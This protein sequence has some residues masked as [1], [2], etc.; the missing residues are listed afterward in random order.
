MRICFSERL[1]VFPYLL[2]LSSFCVCGPAELRSRQQTLSSKRW[3]C[4][5]SWCHGQLGLQ[6]HTS[7]YLCV[8][9]WENVTFDFLMHSSLI[10]SAAYP[11]EEQLNRDT[12]PAFVSRLIFLSLNGQNVL[13]RSSWTCE[14]S[15]FIPLRFFCRRTSSTPTASL[16]TSSA[17]KYSIP[18]SLPFLL[19]VI[20]CYFCACVCMCVCL[21]SFPFGASGVC[22]LTKQG[23]CDFSLLFGALVETSAENKEG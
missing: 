18:F 5:K 14:G 2:F 6:I 15:A 20:A 19:L 8:C 13:L 22:T 17:C 9:V 11:G 4:D 12:G 7:T 1:Q 10:H 3:R 23:P 16:T 21:C